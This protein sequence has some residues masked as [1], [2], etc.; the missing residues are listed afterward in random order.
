MTNDS[1]NA[2]LNFDRNW[3]TS[4]SLEVTAAATPSLPTHHRMYLALKLENA[5]GLCLP[6]PAKP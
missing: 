2:T 5:S 3:K 4:E 6:F 1:P